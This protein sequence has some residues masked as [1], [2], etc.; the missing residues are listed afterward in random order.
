MEIEEFYFGLGEW[1]SYRRSSERIQYR[2]EKGL[3]L[4]LLDG[5][6]QYEAKADE[7]AEFLAEHNDCQFTV[8][9]SYELNNGGR[10][11]PILWVMG[12]KDLPD[13][14]R[15][16]FEENKVHAWKKRLIKF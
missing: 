11:A 16:I 7:V 10:E 4:T 12:W 3:P 1:S 13:T 8:A 14:K 5:T 9:D 2:V 6:S 15:H